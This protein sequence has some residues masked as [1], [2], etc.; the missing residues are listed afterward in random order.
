MGATPVSQEIYRLHMLSFYICCG[1]GIIVFSALIYLLLRFRYSKD[2]VH[3]PIGLEI[4]WTVIPFVL[5]VGMVIPAI[6]IL[7]KIHT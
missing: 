1:L 4:L 3:T 6:K 2:G 7:Y 5:L